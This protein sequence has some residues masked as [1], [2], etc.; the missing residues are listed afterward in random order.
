MLITVAAAALLQ[1]AALVLAARANVRRLNPDA[2]AYLL[3]A[4]HLAKGEVVLSIS[5]FRSPLLS[6]LMAPLVAAG[7]GPLWVAR[8]AMAASAV[9]FF[10]GCV[11]LLWS[12]GSSAGSLVLGA[13][14]AAAASISWSVLDIAPDLLA[15]G[16]VCIAVGAQLSEAWPRDSRCQWLAGVAWGFAYL[17]KSVY[18]PVA[19]VAG[20]GIGCAWVLSRR[21]AVKPVLHGLGRSLLGLVIV[22]GPWVLAISWKYGRPTFSTVAGP[23]H[24]IVGPPDVDRRNPVI[25]E[26]RKPPPGRILWTED[27]TSLPFKDW[28]P[29]ASKAY[30]TFQLRLIDRNFAAARKVLERLDQWRLGVYGAAL[31]VLL[32]LAQRRRLLMERWTW[33][34]VPLLAIVAVYLPVYANSPRYYD[35]TLPLLFVLAVGVVDRLAR[36]LRANGPVRLGAIALVALSFLIPTRSA[37]AEALGGIRDEA[38][39]AAL[40]VT[41]RLKRL[42]LAGPVAGTA[43]V[44]SGLGG[45][46]VAFLLD[47]P[48]YGDKP[49]ATPGEYAASGARL[50]VIPRASPHLVEALDHSEALLDL[51]A[52]LFA[53]PQE[54][55]ACALKVYQVRPS[56]L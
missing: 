14:V 31:L 22:A 32:L 34:L 43:P 8:C 19:L 6:W 11:F 2:M 17:A 5:G 54:A 21:A 44:A 40:D 18:L 45:P 51:D 56:V 20:A 39:E 55:A 48:W 29:F 1:L 52:T 42:H 10:V 35:V 9:V 25:L 46:Y 33:T 24:A 49:N 13:W 38:C 37:M 4:R 53:D 28:S 7:V 47:T 26:F 36:W 3:N 15:A 27:S 23:S 30:A 41:A 16:V 50:I 12:I